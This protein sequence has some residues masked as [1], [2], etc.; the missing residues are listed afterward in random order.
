MTPAMILVW[1]FGLTLATVGHLWSEAWL[2]LKLLLVIGLSGYQGWMIGYGRKLTRGERPVSGK[3]LRL[4][5]EL[6]GIAT[7]AIVILVIVK[8]F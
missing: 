1:V 2:H 3:A 5:N 6:P 7:A 8:P 4:M